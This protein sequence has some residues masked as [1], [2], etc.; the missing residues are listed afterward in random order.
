MALARRQ[1]SYCRSNDHIITGCTH[2][3][4]ATLKYQIFTIIIYEDLEVIN[5]YLILLTTSQLKIV[6]VIMNKP[7]LKRS[8][9]Q[10]I[11]FI[12]IELQS[13]RATLDYLLPERNPRPITKKITIN[14]IQIEE[15]DKNIKYD[16][17][18]CFENHKAT[19]IF[20]TN[21]NHSFCFKCTY[22]HIKS[23]KQSFA[24]CP[25]CRAQLNEL[26]CKQELREG[27]DDIKG[28]HRFSIL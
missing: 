6:C 4:I 11:D 3:T 2:P 13:I 22:Y 14:T 18:I 15:E 27:N 16:C 10:L 23:S 8:R 21:C 1:C 5:S 28:K 7:I 12:F 19:N 25:L 17:P 26:S 24:T 20:L 9:Q